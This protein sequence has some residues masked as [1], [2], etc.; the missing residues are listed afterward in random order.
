MT[1]EIEDK[2]YDLE[3]R[4]IDTL[5][6]FEKTERSETALR[7]STFD[8]LRFCGSLFFGSLFPGSTVRFSFLVNNH[9]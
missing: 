6:F 3:D 4:L 2:A 5:F 8:I 9:P 1:E 7:H